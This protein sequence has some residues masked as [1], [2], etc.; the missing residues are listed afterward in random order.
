M[1]KITDLKMAFFYSSI[2]F[3]IV[4]FISCRKNSVEQKPDNNK[5]KYLVNFSINGFNN[6][7]S[8]MIN[9]NRSAKSEISS[10]SLKKLVRYITYSIYSKNGSN[11]PVFY[12][13]ITQ[14]N[15]EP[16]FG[17]LSDSLP[18]GLYQLYVVAFDSL[19][20]ISTGYMEYSVSPQI[21]SASPVLM[22]LTAGP[23]WHGG[24]YNYANSDYF[25]NNEEVTSFIVDGK[26]ENDISLAL[27]RIVGSVEVNILD[28]AQNP[29]VDFSVFVLIQ[30][31]GT[32]YSFSGDSA[33]LGDAGVSSG[34]PGDLADLAMNN[35]LHAN[36]IKKA[37]G[38]FYAFQSYTNKPFSIII[39]AQIGNTFQTKTIENVVCYR[40]QRT[41][42]S[43]NF[44]GASNTI[45]TASFRIGIDP[46]WLTDSVKINF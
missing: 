9:L 28:A 23:S 29:D 5:N 14:T 31:L 15:S 40:N 27:N 41:I 24:V 42:V 45:N 39:A 10:D 13:S 25:V 3:L 21:N 33:I 16:E 19:S 26:T 32:R 1:E 30:D 17:K 2:I 35:Q 18:Y 36:F 44:F 11:T 4:S 22:N 37:N 7:L 38:K 6:T 12:H 20:E 43:G 46:T 8:P 34:A